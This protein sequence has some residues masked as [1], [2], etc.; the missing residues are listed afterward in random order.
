MWIWSSPVGKET[1]AHLRGLIHGRFDYKCTRVLQQTPGL[2]K[3]CMDFEVEGARP[4]GRPKKTWGEV[5]EK[6]V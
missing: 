6:T 4:R 1:A 3:Q 2:V 5:T